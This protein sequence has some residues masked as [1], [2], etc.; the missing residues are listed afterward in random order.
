MFW[1]IIKAQIL[2]FVAEF[3]KGN[4]TDK[5]FQRKIVDKLVYKVYI[6]DGSLFVLVNFFDTNKTE[7][8]SYDDA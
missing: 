2:E 4:P 6:S 3:V 7:Y 1:R 5:E 8:I